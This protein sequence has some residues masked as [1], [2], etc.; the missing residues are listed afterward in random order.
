[1][2][3]FAWRRCDGVTLNFHEDPASCRLPARAAHAQRLAAKTIYQEHQGVVEVRETGTEVRRHTAWSWELARTGAS[4]L[5]LLRGRSCEQDVAWHCHHADIFGSVGDDKQL[6]LWD[7]RRPPASGGPW[8]LR[9]RAQG[10]AATRQAPSHMH[11]PVCLADVR[12][13]RARHCPG[14]MVAAEAHSAEVNCIAFNPLNPNILATGSADKTVRH[15][16]CSLMTLSCRCGLHAHPPVWRQ[17]VCS[18]RY[19]R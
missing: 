16:P 8:R 6:I 3:S 11:A 10:H 5:R 4:V 19:C 12:P 2:P 7:V 15:S 14:V 17:R 9:S 13:C 1:M 18:T